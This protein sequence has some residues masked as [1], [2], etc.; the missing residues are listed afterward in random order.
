METP[1]VSV[2]VSAYFCH[3]SYAAQVVDMRWED[4]R[5]IIDRVTCAIDCG[6]VV[7]PDAAVNLCEGGIVDG[8]GNAFYGELTFK[9]GVPQKNNFDSYRMIRMSESPRI[10]DVHFVENNID[11]TGLGEPTFP[12]IFAAIANAL[13]K[14]TGKRHYHQPYLTEKVMG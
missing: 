13:Y 6:I 3:N 12:P 4:N 8:I 11:P 10:I 14:T 5:P 1:I 7:N 2:G 9:E